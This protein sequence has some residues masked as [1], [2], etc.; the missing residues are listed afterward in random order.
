M[1]SQE[2]HTIKTFSFNPETVSYEALFQSEG[3]QYQ[4]KDGFVTSSDPLLSNAVGGIKLQ[5]REKD[6]ERALTLIQN[7]DK[8]AK[9]IKVDHISYDEIFEDC[10]N[11]G[12]D[13]CFTQRLNLLQ[14]IYYSFV[15]KN[16]Y[17]Q[18]CKHKWKQH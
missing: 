11:C 3:I 12:T 15:K 1:S 13:Y 2:F 17:C 18:A 10:P 7:I 4:I 8:K 5:V 9:L 14:A 16:Y 6:I